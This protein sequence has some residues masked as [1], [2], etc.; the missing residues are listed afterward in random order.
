MGILRYPVEIGDA[1]GRRYERV[2]A[3]VDTGAMF[4]VFP[5]SQLRRLGVTPVARVRLL[6]GDG[7]SIE[8]ERSE[9]RIRVPGKEAPTFVIFGDEAVPPLLGAYGL[10]GLA[11]MVDPAGQKLVPIEGLL[12]QSTCEPRQ[13]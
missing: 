11:L 6:I 10:E 4:S 5:S 8:R 1:S 12:L 13:P 2:E 3:I 9:A 7:R